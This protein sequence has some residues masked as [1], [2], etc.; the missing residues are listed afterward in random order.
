METNIHLTENEDLYSDN[1]YKENIK[2]LLYHVFNFS[3]DTI[4]INLRA[5]YILYEVLVPSRFQAHFV[6]NC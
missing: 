3:M 5:Q 4:I 6:E 2:L 1:I